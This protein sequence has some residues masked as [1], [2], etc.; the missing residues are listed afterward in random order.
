MDFEINSNSNEDYDYDYSSQEKEI[1]EENFIKE[2]SNENE[3]KDA[4]PL[5][6]I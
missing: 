6:V 4:S 3:S 1:S 2:Y 5:Q